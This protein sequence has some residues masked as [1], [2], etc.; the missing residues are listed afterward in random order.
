MS[1]RLDDLVR[2]LPRRIEPGR[3]LWPGIEG[4]L[5]PRR[6]ASGKRFYRLAAAA[7]VAVIAAGLYF[8]LRAGA[9]APGHAGRTAVQTRARPD[10]DAVVAR[11]LDV[12]DRAIARI[13]AALTRDPGNPALYDFLYQAYRQKGRL[14]AEQAR[15]S[16]TRSYPS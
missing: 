11:N 3:D 2:N 1:D 13:R 14:I 15:L 12:V 6:R 8:G 7:A 10:P 9:P 16:V 5:R 4:R